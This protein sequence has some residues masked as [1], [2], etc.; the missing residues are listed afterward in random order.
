MQ[1]DEAEISAEDKEFVFYSKPYFLR[2]YLPASV[3]LLESDSIKYDDGSFIVK[4]Q[5]ANKGE[6][7]QGLDMLTKLLTNPE[8]KQKSAKPLIGI[9]VLK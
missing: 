7:F 4:L 3:E 9:N 1:V 5:K 6:H 2:L 8:P